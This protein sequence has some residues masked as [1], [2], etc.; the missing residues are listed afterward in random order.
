MR[1]NYL[2]VPVGGT[3]YYLG[4]LVGLPVPDNYV[5]NYGLGSYTDPRRAAEFTATSLPSEEGYVLSGANVTPGTFTVT[6]KDNSVTLALDNMPVASMSMNNVDFPV[7]KMSA[8]NLD[9][10]YTIED[11]VHNYAS[12]DEVRDPSNPSNAG[13]DYRYPYSSS[14][15]NADRGSYWSNTETDDRLRYYVYRTSTTS[16]S[17]ESTSH[18]HADVSHEHGHARGNL[19]VGTSMKSA[20]TVRLNSSSQLDVT[21]DVVSPSIGALLITRVF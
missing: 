19:N 18:T 20:D 11:A 15:W 16:T 6:A 21:I 9:G 7:L 5:V 17:S 8:A 10:F 3:I 2:G 1:D 13:G 14:S 12:T 4:T